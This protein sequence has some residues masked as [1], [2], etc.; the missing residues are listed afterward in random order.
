[1]SENINIQIQ[2]NNF[3]YDIFTLV[4]AFYPEGQVNVLKD[5]EASEA[6][7]ANL[8]I[9]NE[10]SLADRC[11]ELLQVSFSDSK[12]EVSFA[13]KNKAADIDYLSLIHI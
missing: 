7:T 4:K 10:E 2:P 5:A 13:G 11:D 6:G 8:N 9:K 1:M 12:L 3:E